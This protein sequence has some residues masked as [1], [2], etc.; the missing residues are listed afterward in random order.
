MYNDFYTSIY[1]CSVL[2]HHKIDDLLVHGDLMQH[3][4]VQKAEICSRRSTHVPC[5]V[6]TAGGL[7]FVVEDRLHAQYTH[8]C[9]HK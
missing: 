1:V 6:G 4:W 5:L 9:V 2:H 3:A 8:A 7:V